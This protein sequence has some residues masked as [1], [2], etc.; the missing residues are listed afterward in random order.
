[1]PELRA[2][3]RLQLTPSFGFAQAR[4]LVPYLRRLGISHL[5]LSPVLQARTGSEHG[6][7]VID[8]RRVSD[9]LG[10]EDELRRLA[11]A[12]LG[13][14]LDIVPNHMCAS[15]ENPF[16][17]DEELRQQVFDVDPAT[18]FHRRFFDVDDLWGVRQEERTVFDTT[19]AKVLELV[20][21]GLVDGL[22]VD[23]PDGLADPAQYFGW[24]A[25]AGAR[26]VW[27][28]KILA[29]GEELRDWPVEGTT[30]YEFLNDVMAVC[31]EP[32]AETP[33]TEAYEAITGDRRTFAEIAA[34]AKHEVAVDL[35]AP[36]LRRLRDEVDDRE[37]A[38]ALASFHVYRTYVR[39]RD[40]AV[41]E[42]DRD[43]IGR[44]QVTERLRRIL[45]LEERGHDE[46]VV[47]F[48]QT[49]GPLMAK[50]V[51]DTALYRYFRL[52]ALNEVG[53]DPGRFGIGID[54]F[55][56]AN[57]LRAERFPLHLLTTYTHDTKRSPDVRA[58]I[59]A[60][61]WLTDRWLERVAAWRAQLDGL[62]D[63]R[64]ELLVLQTLAGAAPI[65][66]GRLD[67]Y[68]TKALREG[69]LSSSWLA[70]DEAHES[71]VHAYAARAAALVTAN[72]LFAEITAIGRHI[73]AAWLLLK[74]TAP[75]VPDLYQ[76]DELEDLSLVDPD[77][78]RPVDWEARRQRLARIVEGRA[79][80]EETLKL[81]LV[82]KTLGLRAEQPELFAAP[83]EPCELGAGV[84]AFTRGGRLLVAAAVRPGAR[85]A[86]PERWQP[87]IDLPGLV[88]AVRRRL[89]S[90]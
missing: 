58:R 67:R 72:P 74:L 25:E 21:G 83:Y 37:L 33:L 12:G 75:G 3:Y 1:V 19:H 41:A 71:R 7:D 88:L 59:V 78:R 14:I 57:E 6:Y 34:S 81:F 9:A 43:E 64:E 23:H 38:G 8:P 70:P 26:H 20:R 79:P 48:Q 27:A 4:A 60:L 53:G 55:H 30:G 47:R 16:W 32:S 73:A 61:T 65:D 10:G 76:G 54:T 22:R 35:F 68:L 15:D 36:E 17:R 86:V 90:A 52:A 50:G 85:V 62:D 66:A 2:A 42:A 89:P 44:A 49:T 87:V 40:G 82:W 51:E 13:V 28:E 46:F 80:S 45:L 56:A 24:L 39:P 11:G 29:P 77:N 5:Y 69:K 63:P 31:V 18:G 84:C